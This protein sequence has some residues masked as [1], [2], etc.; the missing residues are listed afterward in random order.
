VPLSWVPSTGVRRW[1]LQSDCS[2]PTDYAW[3]WISNDLR[4]KDEQA[5][6]QEIRRWLAHYRDTGVRRISGGFMVLQ[7]CAPGEEW[8]RTESRAVE[9]VGL[10]AG[11]DVLRVLAA[12]S[13]L[14][15]GPDLLHSRFNVPAGILAEARMRLGGGGWVRE[16]IRL[17][18]PARLSYDGQI[19]ENLLRL[20]A[21]VEAGGVAADMVHE[22]SSRPEFA[23]L[24]DLSERIA[25]LVRELVSH[26]MLLPVTD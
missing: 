11:E 6:E 24:P 10:D 9:S 18:S 13:W 3:T 2:S 25:S 5:A 22:I 1:L 12:E 23:A 19:D 8:T 17:T 21:I 16:T 4:F 20:L 15:T 14:A 7:K 26:G